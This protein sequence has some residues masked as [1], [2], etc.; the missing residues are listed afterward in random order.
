MP[1][2]HRTCRTAGISR[3]PAI[4]ELIKIRSVC[5]TY[6]T[7]IAFVLAGTG[8][9]VLFAAAHVSH[10]GSNQSQIGFNATAPDGS[11]TAWYSGTHCCEAGEVRVVLSQTFSVPGAAGY[12]E[13]MC[14]CAAMTTD[15]R[16]AAVPGLP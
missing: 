13:G 5:S 10:W 14:C 1:I 16:L 9:S 12:D 6:F 8:F 4:T 7:L 3:E 11:T 15:R 2:R